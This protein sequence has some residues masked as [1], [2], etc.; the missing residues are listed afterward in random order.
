MILIK[1]PLFS[2]K[3]SV[4]CRTPPVIKSRRKEGSFE[5][6]EDICN[7]SYGHDHVGV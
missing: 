7:F 3:D 6:L 1:V 2:E 5:S 4:V